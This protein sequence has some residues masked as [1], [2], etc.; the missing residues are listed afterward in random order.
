MLLSIAIFPAIFP[1]WWA[2]N[3]NKII[4]SIIA[5]LPL[6]AVV[7]AANP[8]LLT[9]SLQHYLSFLTVNQALLLISSWNYIKG[10]FAGTAHEN[11]LFLP[12]GSVLSNV[13]CTTGAYNLLIR[14]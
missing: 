6:L 4:V 1:R 5:S 10:E 12:V 3:S 14:P 2:S 11:T 9:R 8:S 13:I 7:L